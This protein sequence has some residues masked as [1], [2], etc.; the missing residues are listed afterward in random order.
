MVTRQIDICCVNISGKWQ[1]TESI[2]ALLLQCVFHVPVCLPLCN[3]SLQKELYILFFCAHCYFQ[4][5]TLGMFHM[6]GETDGKHWG[7]NRQPNR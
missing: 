1:T 5:K 2:N 6:D 4:P 3:Y 7:G